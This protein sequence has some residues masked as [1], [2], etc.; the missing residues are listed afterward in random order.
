LKIENFTAET[1]TLLDSTKP[2]VGRSFKMTPELKKTLQTAWQDVSETENKN[3]ETF[4][5]L[6]AIQKNGTAAAWG[7]VRKTGLPS[8][9]FHHNLDEYKHYYFENKKY[10][11]PENLRFDPPEEP[12]IRPRTYEIKHNRFVFYGSILILLALLFFLCFMVVK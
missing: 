8:D 11:V 4:D 5:L 1:K 10:N 6:D 9:E 3:I 12:E 7:I 2:Y